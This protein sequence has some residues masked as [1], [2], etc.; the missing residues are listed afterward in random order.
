MQNKTKTLFP[1]VP[2]VISKALP[3]KKKKSKQTNKKA[4]LTVGVTSSA[5]FTE[6]LT[7]IDH[8]KCLLRGMDSF[9]LENLARK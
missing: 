1:K 4:T 9:L 7:C 5:N 6:H 3:K 2:N 8:T